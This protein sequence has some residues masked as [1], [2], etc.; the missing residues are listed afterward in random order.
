MPE[1]GTKNVG[2]LNLPHASVPPAGQGQEAKAERTLVRL[3]QKGGWAMLQNVHL[4][5]SW[6]PTLVVTLESLSDTADESFRCFLSAELPPLP[7]MQNMPEAL[8]QVGNGRPPPPPNK[9]TW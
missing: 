9:R 5:Q 1:D 2:F 7:T 4:M 3:A 6:L 8:L